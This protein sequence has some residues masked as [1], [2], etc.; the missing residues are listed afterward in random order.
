MT[1]T[2]SARST[3]V[4]YLFEKAA[5][6]KGTNPNHETRKSKV[7][8][9]HKDLENISEMIDTTMNPYSESLLE[10]TNLYCIADG[11]KNDGQNK[12]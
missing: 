6:K 11:K 3:I 1:V 4:R 8:K 2:R 10:D 7:S 12:R 5:I 9:F